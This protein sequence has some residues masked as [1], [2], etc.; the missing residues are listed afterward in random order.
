MFFWEYD[1]VSPGSLNWLP[2]AR[3]I[4]SWGKQQEAKRREKEA[5]QRHAEQQ[6][7]ARQKQAKQQRKKEQS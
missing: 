1:C 5:Q 6:R 4:L 3:P 7:E 2:N